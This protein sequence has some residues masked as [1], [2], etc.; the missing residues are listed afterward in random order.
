MVNQ[1]HQRRLTWALM[2]LRGAFLVNHL[3]SRMDPPNLE[4]CLIEERCSSS[5]NYLDVQ[6]SDAVTMPPVAFGLL[7]ALLAVTSGLI[8]G[9]IRSMAK[10]NSH[11]CFL[12]FCNTVKNKQE[13]EKGN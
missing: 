5:M 10:G 3:Q 7:V 11:K 6:A 4:N 13:N 1:T 2:M 8:K 12:I 9:S